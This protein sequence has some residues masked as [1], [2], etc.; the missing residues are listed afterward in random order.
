M[1]LTMFGRLAATGLCLALLA[2]CGAG[3]LGRLVPGLG[4][5]MVADLDSVSRAKI[6]KFGTAILRV[7]VPALGV[8]VL[9]S[10]RDRHGDAVTWEAA[11]GITFTFRGGVLVETRGLGPDLMSARAPAPSAIASGAKTRRDYYYL[12]DDDRTERRSYD[13]AGENQGAAQV[14]IYGRNH[15]TRQVAEVCQRPEGRITNEFWFEGNKIRQSKQWVSPDAGYA[16]I[17]LVID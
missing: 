7:K 12:W 14:T 5:T 2:S 8:D 3:G 17:M 9:M 11:D 10:E 16:V 13:C 1:A 4:G 6:E 15:A